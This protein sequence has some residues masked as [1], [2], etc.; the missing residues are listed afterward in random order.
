MIRTSF[1]FFA[2]ILFFT[3]KVKAQIIDENCPFSYLPEVVFN[4]GSALLTKASQVALDSF[5]NYLVYNPTCTINIVG[6]N[7][8]KS[9]K[10]IRRRVAAVVDFLLGNSNIQEE[11]L[12]V[13]FDT[14]VATTKVRF[15]KVY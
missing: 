6:S 9:R 15:K 1:L 2:I 13:V 7:N 4:Q 11:R 14:S 5:V 10:L 8:K 3:L 12:I